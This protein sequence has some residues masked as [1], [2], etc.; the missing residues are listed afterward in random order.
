MLLVQTSVII[1]TVLLVLMVLSRY[2]R[3]MI[4]S[5]AGSVDQVSHR[6]MYFWHQVDMPLR[7]TG[8][9]RVLQD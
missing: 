9:A 4:E 7:L 3:T 6:H 5:E 8:L 2:F 1:G